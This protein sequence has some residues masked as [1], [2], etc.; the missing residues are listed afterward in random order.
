MSTTAATAAT[1]AAALVQHKL[2][3]YGT[4]KRGFYNHGVYL[5]TAETR[6]TAVYRGT[7]VTRDSNFCLLVRGPPRCI[8]ALLQCDDGSGNR[9]AVR[10]EVYDITDTVLQAMDVLEG[11]ARGFYYRTEIPVVLLQDNDNNNDDDDDDNVITCWV[12]LQKATDSD[13][14]DAVCHSEYT[15]ALHTK[16]VPPTAEP[17]P[18]I[19]RLL[20]L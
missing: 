13:T 16:Y 19:L 12:Y 8:P 1:A 15:A 9:C 10:G 3:V 2:F 6:Q 7:A 17:D 5:A 20:A 14:D 18:E 11:V 4:L